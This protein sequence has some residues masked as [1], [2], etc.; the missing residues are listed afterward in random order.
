MKFE[1]ARIKWKIWDQNWLVAIIGKGERELSGKKRAKVDYQL[2][3]QAGK[4]K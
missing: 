4:P 3:S 2:A 1:K